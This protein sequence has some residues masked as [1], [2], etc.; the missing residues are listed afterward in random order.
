M[1]SLRGGQLSNLSPVAMEVFDAVTPGRT[2]SD[3]GFRYLGSFD[4]ILTILTGMS[5]EQQLRENI[6]TF[7]PMIP[8]SP[9][10]YAAV[11]EVARILNTAGFINCTACGYCVPC[12]FGVDIPAVL[13]EYNRLL[14]D[15]IAIDPNNPILRQAAMCRG[16]MCGLCEPL[17]PVNLRIIN[18]LHRIED[19]MNAAR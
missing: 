13:V 18:E 8:L 3:W 14:M 16:E 9:D 12:P 17:C 19:L 11:R 15:G 6:R 2:A 7:S 4:G 5:N 10:E 1:S